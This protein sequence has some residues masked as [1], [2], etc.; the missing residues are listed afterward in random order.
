MQVFDETTVPTNREQTILKMVI[1]DY[2]KTAIPVPSL[3]LKEKFHIALSPATIRHALHMLENNGFLNHIH[4]SSGRIPTDC[5]Y[6]FYVDELMDET[7]ESEALN[8]EIDKELSVV[9]LN[10]EELLRVTADSLAQ[11]SSLFGFALLNSN[12]KAKLTDLELISLSSGRVLLVLGFQSDQIR[13][14][15]LNLSVEVKESYVEVVAAVLREHLVGLSIDNIQ[16]TIGERLQDQP[17]YNNE[18][19]QILIENPSNYFS[20]LENQ[21]VCT[22]QKDFLLQHPEFMKSEKIQSIVSALDDEATLINSILTPVGG[23]KTQTSIG[24]ENID[25]AFQN[26]SVVSRQFSYGDF[27]GYLGIIGPTR[28]P[29]RDI[30]TIVN[31][32]SKIIFQ[33]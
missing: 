24:Q 6:R 12:R 3:R 5:G 11:I 32:F 1:E 13:T 30:H 23:S 14:V 21:Q 22:S 29:Y 10:V 15:V 25:A 19:V 27:E 16:Q 20:L 9:V 7:E 8:R 26:C 18:I 28:M 17:V 33:L 2:I 31:T 4:I